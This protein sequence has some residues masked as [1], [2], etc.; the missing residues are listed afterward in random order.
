MKRIAKTLFQKHLNCDIDCL[1][2]LKK[3]GE[4]VKS[5]IIMAIY[6]LTLAA[7][8][9][10]EDHPVVSEMAKAGKPMIIYQTENALEDI[11]Q[12]QT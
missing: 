5:L 11:L 1:E 7:N 6:A 10:Y 12:R 3:T 4:I 2:E 8:A 9:Y